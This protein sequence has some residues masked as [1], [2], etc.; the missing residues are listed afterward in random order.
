ML[1][2]C[3]DMAN[4]NLDKLN[5]I[6]LIFSQIINSV[7]TNLIININGPQDSGK[8][9]F[10]DVIKELCPKA[11]FSGS[12]N[13]LT[14]FQTRNV[15]VDKK[16][17]VLSDSSMKDWTNSQIDFLKKVSGRDK[18]TVKI[19][20]GDDFEVKPKALIVLVSN[21]TFDQV[22]A[23]KESVLRDRVLNLVIDPIVHDSKLPVMQLINLLTNQDNIDYMFMKG[24]RSDQELLNIA[25]RQEKE[26]TRVLDPEEYE[27]D[28]LIEWVKKNYIFAEKW[29][30]KGT[31][32]HENY[33]QKLR[34]ISKRNPS[35]YKHYQFSTAKA[36]YRKF[37]NVLRQ[38]N[39]KYVSKKTGTGNGTYFTNI[40]DIE[41]K[42]KI[43]KSEFFEKAVSEKITK[44]F[45][46][47]PLNWDKLH[48]P[49]SNGIR[50]TGK[51]LS[52]KL[53]EAIFN[54][55]N[56]VKGQDLKSLIEKEPSYKQRTSNSHIVSSSKNLINDVW[57]LKESDFSYPSEYQKEIIHTN[58][59]P[60]YNQYFSIEREDLFHFLFSDKHL[61]FCFSNDTYGEL[62]ANISSFDKVNIQV[63]NKDQNI[64]FQKAKK[65]EQISLEVSVNEALPQIDK[66][67]HAG[68]MNNKLF[69]QP[70]RWSFR[71]C[72]QSRKDRKKIEKKI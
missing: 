9:L 40:T 1:R 42:K 26:A 7:T 58:I 39:P 13:S 53:N 71:D 24:F 64:Y 27:G 54:K 18:I 20:G 25:H 62:F 63:E 72:K 55:L 21:T 56:S 12:L 17:I 30:I 67:S 68:C 44:K 2:W 3:L 46:Q 14:T 59:R 10:I 51:S 48:I 8:S 28:Y 4:E 66:I 29:S 41:N 36:F 70:A 60:T 19:K 22:L 49:C 37:E 43:P 16:V 61:F 34:E 38:L 57:S 35:L 47:N 50:E 5:I 31:Q 33:N 15:V 69:I 32:I 23:F 45:N 52:P 11:F 6:Y 65:S